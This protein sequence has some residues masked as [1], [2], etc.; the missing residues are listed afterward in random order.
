MQTTPEASEKKIA[1]SASFQ[2]RIDPDRTNWLYSALATGTRVELF[3]GQFPEPFT[4]ME[5]VANAEQQHLVLTAALEVNASFT[6]RYG[7]TVGSPKDLDPL[8]KRYP[9][10]LF[11]PDGARLGL[12]RDNQVQG[13]ITRGNQNQILIQREL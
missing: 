9:Q 4:K 6:E 11:T 8:L 12:V 13:V 7:L 3:N 2:L 10:A 5:Y 1:P